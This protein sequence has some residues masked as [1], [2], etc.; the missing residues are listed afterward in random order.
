MKRD[1]E[2]IATY[3]EEGKRARRE[4]AQTRKEQILEIRRTYRQQIDECKNRI[5]TLKAEM[6]TKIND[7]F[8]PE[9]PKA[10]L[11]WLLSAVSRTDG[12]AVLP[13]DYKMLDLNNLAQHAELLTL[14]PEEHSVLTEKLRQCVVKSGEIEQ[15]V[16]VRI[17]PDFTIAGP[18]H[19][20]EKPTLHYYDHDEDDD[21]Q[22]KNL[23]TSFLPYYN[24]KEAVREASDPVGLESHQCNYAGGHTT[25]KVKVVYLRTPEQSVEKDELDEYDNHSSDT[26]DDEVEDDVES[27]VAEAE[28]DE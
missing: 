9:D 12:F 15:Y 11:L 3:L 27:S 16:N 10:H 6:S 19:P 4:Y 21:R 23:R 7:L 5:Q 20:H 8:P 14:S 13:T 22:A 2:S 1:F 25:M 26:S 28:D 24:W 17:N 18:I